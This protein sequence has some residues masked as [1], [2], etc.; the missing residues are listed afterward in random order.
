MR[1]GKQRRGGVYLE[2]R[3][4]KDH[5]PMG[6]TYSNGQRRCDYSLDDSRKGFEDIYPAADSDTSLVLEDGDISIVGQ[7]RWSG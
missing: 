3:G 7:L 2:L 4:C 5:A 6:I 1:E